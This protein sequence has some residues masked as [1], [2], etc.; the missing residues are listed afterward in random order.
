MVHILMDIV[1][2]F[3]GRL[4]ATSRL[5]KKGSPQTHYR[6]TEHLDDNLIGQTES[7]TVLVQYLSYTTLYPPVI[8]WR[9]PTCLQYL[10]RSDSGG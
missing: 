3:R 8:L 5:G 2:R 4:A 10:K 9:L 1:Y 6:V 7:K